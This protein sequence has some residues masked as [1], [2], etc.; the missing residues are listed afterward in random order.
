MHPSVMTDNQLTLS[1]AFFW[2]A[3]ASGAAANNSIGL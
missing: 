1:N 2:L 3:V